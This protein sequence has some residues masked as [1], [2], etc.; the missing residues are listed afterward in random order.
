MSTNA[1]Y[2]CGVPKEQCEGSPS[3]ETNGNLRVYKWHSSREQARKCHIKYMKSQGYERVGNTLVKEGEPAIILTRVSQ[4]GM[5]LRRGKSA[6]GKG[7]SRYM[8]DRN[9]GPFIAK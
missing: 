9:L 5:R 1:A 6:L 3:K 7:A 2:L 8:I 4:F